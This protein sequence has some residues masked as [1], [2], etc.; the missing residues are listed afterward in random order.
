MRP[1]DDEADELLRG[2]QYGGIVHDLRERTALEAGRR[3][4][5]VGTRKA[6]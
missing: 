3:S 5:G 4:S 6:D 1:A 2:I